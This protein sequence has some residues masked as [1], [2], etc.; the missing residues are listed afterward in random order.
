METGRVEDV[1]AS[2]LFMGQIH[3][4]DNFNAHKK[5]PLYYSIEPEKLENRNHLYLKQKLAPQICFQR[6]TRGSIVFVRKHL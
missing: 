2:L 5:P 3:Q 4:I 1:F 6:V